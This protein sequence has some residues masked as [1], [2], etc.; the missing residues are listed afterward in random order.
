MKFIRRH[1][2]LISALALASSP[3]R[4]NTLTFIEQMGN[5][6]WFSAGNWFIYVAGTGPGTGYIPA[7]AL[8]GPGDTAVITTDV[9][10]AANN[11]TLAGLT[12]NG[13]VTV[14]GGD[15]TVNSGLSMYDLSTF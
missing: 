1:F 9:N 13:G 2:F 3:A 8:P 7:N 12:L 4:A 15:F 6:S 5:Y 11:I 14:S 10:A